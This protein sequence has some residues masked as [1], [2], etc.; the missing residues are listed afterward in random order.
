[1]RRSDIVAGRPRRSA[2]VG[3]GHVAPGVV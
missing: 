2:N 1:V 3:E